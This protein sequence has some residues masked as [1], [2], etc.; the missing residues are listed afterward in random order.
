MA[1][2]APPPP[3]HPPPYEAPPSSAL[4]KALPNLGLL[5]L[6]PIFHLLQFSPT[7]H[8]PHTTFAHPFAFYSLTRTPDEISMVVAAHPQHNT[9][10][11]LQ[12]GDLSALLKQGPTEWR[13]FKV[14]GP[15]HHGKSGGPAGLS[16]GMTGVMSALSAAL[17]AAEIPI[18]ALS[19]WS[20]DYVLV[21]L[22]KGKMA[23]EALRNDGWT[24]EDE[25]S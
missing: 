14:K 7:V 25:S 3:P 17:A 15:L 6:G 23:A 5:L 2:A 18:F 24:V 1:S 4:D 9:K 16:V 10:T 19:T 20:T 8:L 12:L 11:T 22:D 21:P 13:G